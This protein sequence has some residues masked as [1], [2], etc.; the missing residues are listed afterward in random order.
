LR[1]LHASLKI[2]PDQPDYRASFRKHHFD[3]AEARVKAGNHAA[4]RR[5]VADLTRG[6]DKGEHVHQVAVC[7]LARCV[8]L[9]EAG[10]RPVD[11]D[12][13]ARYVSQARLLIES[14]AR[15]DGKFVGRLKADRDFAPLLRRDELALVLGEKAPHD[16]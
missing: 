16:P 14:A 13:V 6:P 12:E 4:A 11:P 15:R 7:F 5:W 2:N 8:W 1:E 10:P 3:L 9:V